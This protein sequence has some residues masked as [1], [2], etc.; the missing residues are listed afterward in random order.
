[1]L[2]RSM[3]LMRMESYK[4]IITPIHH[5][6]RGVQYA[7]TEYSKLLREYG[8]IPS[9]TGIANVPLEPRQEEYPEMFRVVGE[10]KVVQNPD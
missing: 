7:S 8:S 6:D 4:D 1:M 5:S 2:F 3:A 10:L 9:I